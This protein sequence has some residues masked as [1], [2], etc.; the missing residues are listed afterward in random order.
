M[1]DRGLVVVRGAGDLATGI[2]HRLWRS[3][4]SVL[5]LETERPMVVRRTVSAASAVFD[6]SAVIE[7][8]E[9]ACID[10]LS[11]FDRGD[12][13]AFVM[14]DPE[15]ASIDALRPDVVVDAIMAKR[16][17]GTHR[18]MARIVVAIGPGHSAPRDVHAV[19]ETQRGHDLGRV[20]TDGAAAPNT[21]VPGSIGGYTVERLL[22]AP[23][24]GTVEP[25]REIGDAV[26]A[27]EVIAHVGGEPLTSQIDGVLRGLIHPT[28]QV[29]KGMKIG[30]V[31]PRAERSHCF[32]I[33]DKALA[34]AGGVLEAIMREL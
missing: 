2:I 15:G 10:D 27:G 7:G 20:I 16:A 5:A 1:S 33:S 19:V 3:R 21:G 4:F 13:R 9:V 18:G 30:D 32:T 22:R 6:G 26:K 24:D 25:L 28:V 17:T 31:D 34:V 14:V 23:A 11:K 12:G 29:T 8:M